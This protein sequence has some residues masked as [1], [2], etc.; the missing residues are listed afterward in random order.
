MN[1]KLFSFFIL[2]TVLTAQAAFALP[3]PIPSRNK[4]TL[5]VLL[6]P[7][8]PAGATGTT[9]PTGS[10][11]SAGGTGAT[12]PG[13]VGF[14][15]PTGATGATGPS[16]AGAAGPTG[17][18]GPTG[19]TGGTGSGGAGSLGPT[20]PTGTTA[21]GGTIVPFASGTLITLNSNGLQV[22]G[23]LL[24]ANAPFTLG[25]INGN[26]NI[27][28][29]SVYSAFSMPR[30]GTITS[31]SAFFSLSPDANFGV[32]VVSIRAQIYT[33]SGPS[34]LYTLVAG[35]TLTLLPTLTGNLLEGT[36]RSGILT[37]LSIPLTVNTNVMLVFSATGATSFSFTGFGNGGV[38]I[39]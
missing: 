6:Q 25:S 9:G 22:G 19:P 7:T 24:G 15:G 32:S 26:I 4:D 10:N 1:K 23:L 13:G 16:G 14:T 12:G 18:R 2:G 28:S 34:A 11:G 39:N 37:G 8:G 30:S 3:N 31:I 29:S 27:T 20:G 5:P 35:T 36:T 33:S 38:A 17:R 21:T